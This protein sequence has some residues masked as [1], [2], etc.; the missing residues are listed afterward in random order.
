VYLSVVVAGGITPVTHVISVGY[1]SEAEMEAWTTTRDASAD[2][3]T[4][5]KESRKAAEY[6]G[7][8]L[9]REL[10]SWGPATLSSLSGH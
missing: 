10:K 6:L 3:A 2:W 7:G 4:F 1:D 9:A 8:S 5:Q